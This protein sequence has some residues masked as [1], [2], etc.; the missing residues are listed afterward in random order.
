MAWGRL[1]AGAMAFAV[2]AGLVTACGPSFSRADYEAAAQSAAARA[3]RTISDQWGTTPL[4]RLGQELP[5]GQWTGVRVREVCEADHA[6]SFGAAE[7]GTITCET[8]Y[9]R[10]GG[11]DGE[12]PDVLRTV[13]TA[14]RKLGWS[15]GDGTLQVALG[16]YETG[17]RGGAPVDAASVPAIGYTVPPPAEGGTGC[18]SASYLRESSVERSSDPLRTSF[19][20]RP[21][22]NP[23]FERSSG[24]LAVTT[25]PELLRGHRF[26]LT[27][28][29]LRQCRLPLR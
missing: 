5:A 14:A 8:N 17:H 11:F 22:Y 25:A 16:Y 15:E 26:V 18:S 19:T 29:L 9:V 3:D 2:G 6:T 4:A 24:P 12:L 7:P 21:V 23:V 13:D 10:Q 28:A 27:F 1:V 20:E